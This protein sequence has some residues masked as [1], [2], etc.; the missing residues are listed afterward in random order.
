MSHDWIFEMLRDLRAYAL[1]NG[2]PATAA[3]TEEALRI[4]EAEVAAL[5]APGE[6]GEAPV[7]PPRKGPARPH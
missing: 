7:S 5:P 1:A 4:A 3:K 2:L 6:G